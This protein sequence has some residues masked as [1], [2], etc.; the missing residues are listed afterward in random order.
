VTPVEVIRGKGPVILAMPHT[1]TWM[2]AE[3][4]DRLNPAGRALIDTDW[5]VDRLYAGLL[6]EATIVRA[7]FHRYLIDANRGPDD[8][9]LYPGRATT[10]L[11][12]HT[13]FDG[14]EIYR[15]DE[16]PDAAEIA[17]RLSAFHEPYHS[18]LTDEIDRVRRLHGV[19]LLYDCHSIRSRVPRLFEGVLP[20]VNVGTNDGSTCAGAVETAIMEEVCAADGYSACLNGRFKGGWTV[21]HHGRPESG[22]H[23]IQMELAQ[24]TYLAREAPPWT[25]D[26][27]GAGR[28]RRSLA[29]I[30]AAL[31]RLAPTLGASNE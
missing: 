2:P 1:A 11:C 23:A 27:A 24:S 6:P 30:L 15:P 19:A 26:P 25:Y 18:A 4:L 28:L 7:T 5:H 9:S 8:A 20:D 21:R 31:A 12:P 13:D 3:A 22:V 17:A 16:A 14:R 10:G 29:R